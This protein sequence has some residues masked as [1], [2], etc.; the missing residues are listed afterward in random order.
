M[1]AV[2]NYE[3]GL[4]WT[5]NQG[6]GTSAYRAYSRAHEVTAPGRPPLEGSSDP[7]FRGETDRW[8]PELLLV[9]ALSGCHLMSYLH[10]CVEA[11]VTVIAYADAPTGLM[12]QTPGGGGRFTE[13]V[14]RP[15]VMLARESA[16]KHD[17]A[18]RLHRDA[19]ARCFIA[20]S[21]NFPVRHEPVVE[22]AER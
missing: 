22:V 1:V 3:L 11:G 6:T 12:T 21:V 7:A 15:R 5:G 14:L 18:V 4:V 9:A 13:V 16:G 2:H 19:S 17:L 10:V 8:N 20:S